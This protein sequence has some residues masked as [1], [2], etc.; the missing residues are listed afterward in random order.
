MVVGQIEIKNVDYKYQPDTPFESIALQ[1]I[2]FAVEQG[3]YTA[4]IGH[5]GSGKSTLIQLIDGLIKPTT[6]EVTV[7]DKHVTP[8]SSG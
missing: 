4:V 5:T 8:D 1:E 3:T 6:G 2:N 7:V